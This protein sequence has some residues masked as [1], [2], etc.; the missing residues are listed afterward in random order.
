[1]NLYTRCAH[2]ETVFRVTT[3]DLQA[4]SGRVRCGHCHKVFD[5]FASLSAQDPM[6]GGTQAEDATPDIAPIEDA[7]VSAVTTTNDEI[8]V[9]AV[10]LG[11]PEN[12]PKRTPLPS[13]VATGVNSEDPAASL[14]E[15][16]F[17]EAPPPRRNALWAVLSLLLLCGAGAQASYAYRTEILVN[18]PQM[19]PLFDRACAWIGCSIGL[20]RLAEWLHIES[21][22]LQ[23]FDAGR[24][25]EV[26]LTAL[27]RNRAPV[28]VEYP[29]FELTLTNAAEQ[30][31]ARRVLRPAEYLNAETRVEEGLRG[32]GELAIRLFLDTGKIRASGYRVYL[33]Y[34]A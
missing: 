18:Y 22:D 27:V 17:K 2:C 21:S 31:I 33:F 13:T 5:A 14:Y 12:Q 7:T 9:A 4:S 15:W 29:A 3:R 6:V 16:E 30:V 28:A 19:R 11:V 1:M 32:R 26:E 24:A 23:Q 34:P 8:A 20:P 10:Q 25:G